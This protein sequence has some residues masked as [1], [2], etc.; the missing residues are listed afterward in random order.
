MQAWIA[1]LRPV[2]LVGMGVG[3]VG[4]ALRRPAAVKAQLPLTQIGGV[5][6]ADPLD[7]SL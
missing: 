6:P 7:K 2:A 1:E 4:L 3:M 5:T